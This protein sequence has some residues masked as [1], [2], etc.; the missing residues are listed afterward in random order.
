MRICQY[1]S[2][3]ANTKV[4]RRDEWGRIH[5]V[6]VCDDHDGTLKRVNGG[7]SQKDY[8]EGRYDA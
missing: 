8:M 3:P 5:D 7:E 1:C 6:F 4:T 2:R